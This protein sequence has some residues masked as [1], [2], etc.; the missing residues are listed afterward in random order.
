[1]YSLPSI[2]SWILCIILVKD[3][4]DAFSWSKRSITHSTLKLFSS[5]NAKDAT[6]LQTIGN[7]QPTVNIDDLLQSMPVSEKYELLLQSYGSKLLEEKFQ[8]SELMN[9]MDTLMQEMV[10]KSIAP[11]DN[12]VKF[13]M[14]AVSSFCNLQRLTTAIETLRLGEKLIID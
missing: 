9:K 5:K 13:Y 10:D 4:T 3:Y 7:L 6:A 8:D 14:D 2:L 1:M 12:S 11:E